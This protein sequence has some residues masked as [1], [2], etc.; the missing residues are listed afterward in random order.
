MNGNYWK[1]ICAIPAYMFLLSPSGNTVQK[2]EGGGWIDKH[3][4]QKVIDAA[5]DELSELREERDSLRTRIDNFDK[6]IA[7][8]PALARAEKL[9]SENSELKA[10][11]ER[12]TSD[13]EKAT[14]FQLIGEASL[15]N[16]DALRASLGLAHGE[17]LHEHVAALQ[18]DAK[19]WSFIR[20]E[21]PKVKLVPNGDWFNSCFLEREIDAAMSKELKP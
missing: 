10:E 11:V 2:L 9:R 6:T 7:N 5:E 19:R 20:D 12:L 8:V 16:R 1:Q 21:W 13:L 4:A 15:A 14:E 17:N 18:K 3:E